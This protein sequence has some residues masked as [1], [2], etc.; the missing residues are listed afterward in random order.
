MMRTKKDIASDYLDLLI[1]NESMTQQE[2]TE[3]LE[4]PE[5][6]E[7]VT[8]TILEKLYDY[9]VYKG[10]HISTTKA[11]YLFCEVIIKH[12]PMGR[13]Y[14]YW[15]PFVKSQF[16]LVEKHGNTAYLAP[17]GHGKCVGEDTLI[18]LSDGTTKKI[19]DVKKGDVVLSFDEETQKIVKSLVKQSEYTGEKLGFEF[20]LSSGKKVIVSKDHPFL[21]LGK[22]EFNWSKAETLKPGMFV[23]TPRKYDFHEKKKNYLELARLLGYMIAE[24]CLRGTSPTFSNK[25]EIILDDF[26]HC[27]SKLGIQTNLAQLKNG[28]YDYRLKG[29]WP[30]LRSCGLGKESSYHKK[31][32][33]RITSGTLEEKKDFIKTLWECDG[34]IGS[35]NCL[36]YV[37]MSEELI[38]GLQSLLLDFGIHAM[39]RKKKF[40]F[41]N[42]KF[43]AFVLTVQGSGVIDFSEKIGL[44]N[45]QKRLESICEDLKLKERNTNVDVIPSNEI[46][47]HLKRSYLGAQENLTR[48]SCKKLC[49]EL[50][51]QTSRSKKGNAAMEERVEHLKS[52]DL[53]FYDKLSESDIFWEEITEVNELGMIPMYDLEIEG[54]HNFI[55]NDIFLHNTSFL[56]AYMMF[57]QFLVKDTRVLYISNVPA[58]IVEMVEL[59][60]KI[61]DENELLTER[62]TVGDITWNRSRQ[63]VRYNG[64]KISTSG[65][66]GTVRG[67]H[68]DLIV[69][70]DLLRKGNQYSNEYIQE[71]IT[72]DVIPTVQ[73]S[74]GRLILVGTVKSEIDIFHYFM[75]DHEDMTKSKLSHDTYSVRGGFYCR[76]YKA[77]V[78]EETKEVLDPE[79]FSYE[80]LMYIKTVKMGELDFNREYQMECKAPGSS[81]VSLGLFNGCCDSELMVE[82]KGMTVIDDDGNDTGLPC[83]YMIIV[84]S[85]SSDAPTAD[86]FAS[87][88][89]KLRS[90][91]RI[92]VVNLKNKK[93][94]SVIDKEGGSDPDDSQI[95]FLAAWIKEYNNAEIVVE[96]NAAGVAVTQGLMGKGFDVIEHYTTGVNKNPNVSKFVE[97]LKRQEVI[98]PSHPDC[99]V[100]Q[101]MLRLIKGEVLKFGIKIIRGKETYEALSG[102]DDIFDV[103]YIGFK[104]AGEGGEPDPEAVCI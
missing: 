3:L 100:T 36:E 82:Q 51:E 65:V 70:D 58:V 83:D 35:R 31:I 74:G 27:C 79:R 66:G 89:L 87:V 8:H 11:F 64:G 13:N 88:V 61:V 32:P 92:Q 94:F 63:E 81:L 9:E 99:E 76:V 78:N 6:V 10:V 56:V 46:R 16:E 42:K 5:S 71:F 21:T 33:E 15:R 84:D 52:L 4:T 22:G 104:Y 55:G 67:K 14:K 48:I 53:T 85:A 24:G 19:K 77:I 29:A 41:N 37:S 98:F 30:L 97:G 69:L 59:Y 18:K 60:K 28:C 43:L 73:E 50:R 101:E 49:K 34:N 20:V 7:G 68:V 23:G 90:D 54:T 26:K 2:K 25:N 72:M 40:K 12:H 96:Q 75:S 57:K 38:L 39:M 45:K 95:E 91:G 103:L 93:G 80:K 44:I 17:R 47:S 86:F 102:H 1:K 62:K